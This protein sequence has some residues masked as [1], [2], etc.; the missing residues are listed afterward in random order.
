MQLACLRSVHLPQPC[1]C[2]HG[3]VLTLHPRACLQLPPVCYCKTVDEEHVC[4]KC[5]IVNSPYLSPAS[6]EEQD[7]VHVYQLQHSVRHADDRDFATFLNIV[8]NRRPTAAELQAIL[9]EQ[10]WIDSASV[11]ERCVQDPST[12]VLCSHRDDVARYNKDILERL[13][14]AGVVGPVYNTPLATNAADDTDAHEWLQNPYHHPLQCVALGARV[15]ITSNV[16]V[17]SAAANGATGVVE[18]IDFQPGTAIPARLAV[19]LD[20]TGTTIVLRRSLVHTLY[21]GSTAYYKGSFPCMLAYA[22][23]GHKS[24]GATL[25]GPTIVHVQR[26]FAPGLLYVMLSRVT[27]RKRLLVVRGLTTDDFSPVVVGVGA[28]GR[29]FHAPDLASEMDALA[30]HMRAPFDAAGADAAAPAAAAM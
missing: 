19:K 2:K 10:Y 21:V 26:A 23:T 15:M 16:D 24:Q 7:L 1:A 3:H 14:D 27:T 28:C 6:P 8:R 29:G 12:T 18:K 4:A 13:S 22:M 9:P 25:A 11:V 30:E 20:A 17:A 5:H